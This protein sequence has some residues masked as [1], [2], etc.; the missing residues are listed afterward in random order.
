MYCLRCLRNS[1]SS[2]PS[3]CTKFAIACIFTKSCL[4]LHAQFLSLSM[5]PSSCK[6]GHYLTVYFAMKVE[7]AGRSCNENSKKASTLP[8]EEQC[9]RK[10]HGCPRQGSGGYDERW[11]ETQE[12]R[13]YFQDKA[14]G[15]ASLAEAVNDKATRTSSRQRFH[16]KQG[17]ANKATPTRP[18]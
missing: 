15:I 12:P 8:W 2:F 9:D 11:K 3:G 6:G 18:R 17:H 1:S 14:R 16:A 13:S 7:E 4:D 5:C 10:E